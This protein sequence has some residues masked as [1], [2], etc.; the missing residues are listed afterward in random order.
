M[1][2]PEHINLVKMLATRTKEGKLI[3]DSSPAGETYFTRIGSNGVSIKAQNGSSLEVDYCGNIYD[4][5][6]LIVEIFSAR[7]LATIGIDNAYTL[8]DNLYNLARRS[9]LGADKILN[10]IL[11]DLSI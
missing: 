1:A 3:W 7:E 6:G 11:K 5:D 4:G 9:A 10:Q 8:L 2:V